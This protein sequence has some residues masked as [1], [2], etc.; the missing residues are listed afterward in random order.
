MCLSR[1]HIRY[2]LII[3]GGIL[4]TCKGYAM[5]QKFIVTYKVL[6]SSQ[7]ENLFLPEQANGSET[8]NNNS[9]LYAFG[10]IQIHP[11]YRVPRVMVELTFFNPSKKAYVKSTNLGWVGKSDKRFFL[12]YLGNQDQ[13]SSIDCSTKVLMEK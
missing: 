4:L 3:L 12:I 8:E 2:L 7:L 10:Y 1:H 11:S 6:T 13:F 9:D 5:E